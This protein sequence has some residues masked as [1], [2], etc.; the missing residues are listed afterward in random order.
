[1]CWFVFE[2]VTMDIVSKSVPKGRIKSMQDDQDKS[3]WHVVVQK[4]SIIYTQTEMQGFRV[5]TGEGGH[6]SHTVPSE[7]KACHC[8]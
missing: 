7:V 4:C 5:G 8:Q 6:P 3:K 1:M 2:T